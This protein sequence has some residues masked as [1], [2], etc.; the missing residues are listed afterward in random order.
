MISLFCGPLQIKFDQRE[1]RYLFLGC[2]PPLFYFL[3]LLSLCYH[4]L[5]SDSLQLTSLFT[6]VQHSIPPDNP[7]EGFCCQI[8]R[9]CISLFLKSNLLN[10]LRGGGVVYCVPASTYNC[11]HFG[12]IV[13]YRKRQ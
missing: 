3:V 6:G 13:A 4:P 1:G 10:E 9:P 2:P 5:A 12:V 8:G 7:I 11:S